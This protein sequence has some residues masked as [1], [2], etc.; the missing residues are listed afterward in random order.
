MRSLDRMGLTRVDDTS[1]MKLSQSIQCPLQNVF[2]HTL[3]QG[4]LAETEEITGQERI[5]VK[6]EVWNRVNHR[7]QV[8]TRC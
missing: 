6:F 3:R 5:D 2:P 7:P 1:I 4:S 8:G